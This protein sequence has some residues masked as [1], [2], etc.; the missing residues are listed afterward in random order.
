MGNSQRYAYR[1]KECFGLKPGLKY[2]VPFLGDLTHTQQ[3]LPRRWLLFPFVNKGNERGCVPVIKSKY[4][5]A[6][7]AFRVP[8]NLETIL[9]R[10]SKVAR[11]R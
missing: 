7:Y 9:P 4:F 2:E 5:M 8:A 10:T 1:T 3:S 6:N 11:N